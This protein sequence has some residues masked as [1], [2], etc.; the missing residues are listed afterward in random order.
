MGLD[1]EFDGA[2]EEVEKSTVADRYSSA[3]PGAHRLRRAT[4]LTWV[5]S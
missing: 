5:F 4:L 3:P 1:L 2:G